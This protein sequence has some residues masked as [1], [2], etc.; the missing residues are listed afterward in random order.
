MTFADANFVDGDFFNFL[1]TWFRILLA[2][3]SFL[4]FLDEIPTD[5]EMLGNVQDCHMLGQ[6][7]SV[8]LEGFGVAASMRRESDFGLA[9]RAAA[10]TC[11]PLSGKIDEDGFLADGQGPDFAIDLALECNVS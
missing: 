1:K 4:D 2:E 8:S 11:N 6:F 10:P 3:I 7:Q 9:D 5:T